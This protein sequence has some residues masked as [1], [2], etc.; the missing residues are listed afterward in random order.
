M[1]A[2]FFEDVTAT[3]DG[4]TGGIQIRDAFLQASMQQNFGVLVV[5]LHHEFAVPLCGRGT[6]T[7]V[8]DGFYVIQQAI[9]QLNPLQ[10][11]MLV[12]IIG[13]IAVADIVE[14]T[15]VRQV[16][17]DDDVGATLIV[18]CLHDVTADKT[19]AACDNNHSLVS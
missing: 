10:E 19:G 17:N 1:N 18:Q 2:L 14:L 7:F 9:V 3:I 5:V 4:C 6:G 15:T 16:I 8:K 13:N 11:I 12:E